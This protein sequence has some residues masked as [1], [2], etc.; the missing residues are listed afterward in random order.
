MRLF[1]IAAALTLAA[2]GTAQSTQYFVLPDSQ[3]IRPTA[4]GSEVAVKVNLAAPLADGGLVYQTDEYH[5]NLAKNHLWAAP[6]EGAL[7]ANLSNKLNHRLDPRRTYVPAARSQ[8]GQTLK[9]YIEA[10]QGSYRGQTAVSGYAVYPDGRSK[11]FNI[12]TPQ[13]GDGY[14]AMVE[15]LEKGLGEA[16]KAI[17]Y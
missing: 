16:A 17:A 8:S 11:P 9:I 2:C 13:Q 12:A 10:F 7:T 5:V 3:Y 15:S 6:L 14:P 1:P 4:Q